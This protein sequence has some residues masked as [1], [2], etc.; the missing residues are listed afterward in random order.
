MH[1]QISPPP[2][3]F[4]FQQFVLVHQDISYRN[5]ILDAAGMVWL[6]GWAHA[7]AYPRAF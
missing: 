4:D 7:G 3:P 2:P 5:I 1:P 6:V